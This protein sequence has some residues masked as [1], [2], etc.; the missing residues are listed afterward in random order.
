MSRYTATLR[1]FL[2]ASIFAALLLLPVFA[3]ASPLPH[4]VGIRM[5]YGHG[6]VSG[7]A[8]GSDT[9]PVPASVFGGFY[10]W[11][12]KPGLA[13]QSELLLSFR[14]GIQG[15]SYDVFQEN[16]GYYAYHVDAR[17][18]WHLTYI[19]VPVLVKLGK[20]DIVTGPGGTGRNF[21]PFFEYGLSFGMK[22][23]QRYRDELKID[24]PTWTP[25]PNAEATVPRPG[26][27]KIEL[28][29]AVGAGG[30]MQVGPGFFS[31]QV[32]FRAGMGNLGGSSDQAQTRDIM[33]LLG[34]GLVLGR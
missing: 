30:E 5:G 18:E 17:S 26:F 25:M 3:T 27:G 12:L 34:Y 13:I 24:Y 6:E 2:A 14:G 15:Q 22:V 19:E 9:D 16:T 29:F 8:I 31:F 1:I 33:M 11:W 10:S 7:A 21:T 20:A 28:S 4:H 23:D 32:R